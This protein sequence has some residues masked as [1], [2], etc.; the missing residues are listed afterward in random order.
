MKQTLESAGKG[1]N[2]KRFVLR[3]NRTGCKPVILNHPGVRRERRSCPDA[4]NCRK[5][6]QPSCRPVKPGPDGLTGEAWRIQES[7]ETEEMPLMI[8]TG[9][10]IPGK[11]HRAGRRDLKGGPMLIEK[12]FAFPAK[13]GHTGVSGERK[14]FVVR[15]KRRVFRGKACC[16]QKTEATGKE[17]AL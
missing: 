10:R 2:G 6:G 12:A 15:R 17:K 8:L 1:R 9:V 5:S 3:G 7:C 14:R 13:T 4:K 16:R 11:R